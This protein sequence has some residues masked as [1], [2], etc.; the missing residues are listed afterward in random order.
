LVCL[1]SGTDAGFLTVRWRP[2]AGDPPDIQAWLGVL[3]ELWLSGAPVRAT[4]GAFAGYLEAGLSLELER[5]LEGI[6]QKAQILLLIFFA[7]GAF[8]ILLFPWIS[9]LSQRAVPG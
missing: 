3:Q 7:P 1:E 6:P 5:H 4:L 9:A 2:I 8:F